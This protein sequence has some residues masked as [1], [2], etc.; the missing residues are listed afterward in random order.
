[1]TSFS[2]LSLGTRRHAKQF[3]KGAIEELHLTAGTILNTPKQPLED[4]KKLFA[5]SDDVLFL[6]GHYTSSL[7]NEDHSVDLTFEADKLTVKYDGQSTVL[8]CG[9]SSSSRIA[10]S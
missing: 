2:V 5:R 3:R 7:Y 4:I 10:S 1:M 9:R 6:A 8:N